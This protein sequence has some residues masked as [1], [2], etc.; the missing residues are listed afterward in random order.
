MCTYL[1]I[2]DTMDES[3]KNIVI[4]LIVLALFTGAT[5]EINEGSTIIGILLFIFAL[6]LLIKVNFQQLNP[7]DT[8]K[9]P[10]TYL[11]VGF[12]VVGSDLIYNYRTGGNLGTLDTMTVTFGFSL[13]GSYS[14]N[15][16][17]NRIS[18][19]GIYISSTFILLFL[20]FYSMFAA[21]NIDL[22][23]KF[24]HFFILLP[25]VWIMDLAG[26][27][28]EVIA[29]ETVRLNGVKDMIV[30][31][32][33]PCSGLYSMFFLIGTVLGYSRIEKMNNQ[34]T[35][36]MLGLCITI[37]YVSNLFRVIILYL[38]A[39]FYGQEAM[40]TVHTHIGWMLFAGLATLILY[41]IN[42]QK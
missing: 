5:I 18:K 14:K 17:I 12:L 29:T 10:K 42:R 28:V 26:I 25:T 41:V 30:V 11:L 6:F 23:H 22:M 34:K 36:K 19:F 38:T 32:G 35:I 8:L 3:Q 21:L 9:K 33:G 27:P 39:Y 16:Q 13:M 24:N 2:S 7:S 40:M 37:A 15:P 1:W 20:I 31:I 4:I